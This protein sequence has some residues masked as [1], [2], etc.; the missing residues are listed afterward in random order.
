MKHIR[1]FNEAFFSQFFNKKIINEVENCKNSDEFFSI[2]EDIYPDT[3]SAKDGYG[4]DLINSNLENWK[5][6]KK[7]LLSHLYK[8]DI[9]DII[10]Y[11]PTN[12]KPGKSWMFSTSYIMR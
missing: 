8:V 7:S 9:S 2:I 12:R 10:I 3:K 1:K 6:I 5:E 11:G 4:F